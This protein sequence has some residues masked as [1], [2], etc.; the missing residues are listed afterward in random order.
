[1]PPSYQGSI[2]QQDNI[3]IARWNPYQVLLYVLYA[4]GYYGACIVIAG[5]LRSSCHYHPVL[6][7]EELKYRI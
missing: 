2:E 4:L 7:M 6:Q 3:Q 1:M 5:I